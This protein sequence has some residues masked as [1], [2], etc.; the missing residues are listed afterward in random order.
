MDFLSAIGSAIVEPI[1][2]YTVQPVARQ[3]GY[4]NHFK[5]NLQ[6]LEARVEEL[7]AAREGKNIEVA[8]TQRKGEGIHPDVQLWL[9]KVEEIT[10]KTDQFLKDECSQENLK[11]LH[12]FC[13]N[14]TMRHRLSRNSTKLLQEV[15][16]LHERRRQLPKVS[17]GVLREEACIISTG[18]YQAFQSRRS[19]FKEIMD[20]LLKNP[21]TIRIGVY[22]IG[23]VGKSTLVKEVYRQAKQ[24][25][26]KLFDDVVL[27]LDVKK[28]S[29]PEDLQKKIVEKL[30]M[31]ISQ[32]DD[33]TIDGRAKRLC[34]RIKNKNVLVILDDV[35]EPI[36]LESVGLPS[37]AT[38][39]ILLTSRSRKAL[40]DMGTHKDFQLHI[41]GEEE[42]WALFENKAGDVVKD[43]AIQTVA[44]QVA[45]NCGGLPVLVVT[46]ASALKNRTTLPPWKD[47]LTCLQEGSDRDD[48]LT[49]KAYLGLEWS[50]NQLTDK[51]LKPLFLLCGYAVQ[52]NDI[53]L[54][55][56]LYYSVGLGFFEKPYTVEKAQNALYSWV[57]KLKDF[58]LLVESD[59]DRYVTMHDL[60]RNAANRI[61]SRDPQILAL[62]KDEDEGGLKEW[63]DRSFL[64]KCTT[65]SLPCN[66]NFPSLPQVMQ[67]PALRMFLLEGNSKPL[68]IAPTL[69]KEMKQLNV[70]SWINMGIGSLPQSLGLLEN[71]RTLC[72]LY[73]TL[74]EISIVGQLRNLEIL[75]FEGSDF[76]HLPQEIGQLAHLR[77]LDLSGCCRLE[78][79]SPGVISSL[80]SLE[81][82]T[83]KKK[84]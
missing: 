39:K 58:C 2:R 57:E 74:D 37:V 21:N 15:V 67:C 16:E 22:G 12:G 75:S 41:L 47:A 46:V 1:V 14:L 78:V 4:V 43:P 50:Y 6:K 56:L 10:A 73:C 79:I 18:D 48:E 49:E 8:E 32:S 84:L 19:T 28:N 27:V 23:G 42:T 36:D 59:D 38:C 24:D 11:C 34:G 9:K 80:T 68:A 52:W 70:L 62:V 25:Q 69:F 81:C 33:E 40:S 3:V 31:K 77:L 5:R 63:P 29:D 51:Q 72:L 44:K 7:R 17:C 65:I 54:D 83:M 82:L 55:D 13:P 30:D 76:V 66:G 61:A 35:W 45:Q 60:V 26:T 53:V 64:E 20:E 71:L